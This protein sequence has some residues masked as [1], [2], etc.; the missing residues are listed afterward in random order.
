MG[1]SVRQTMARKQSIE[2]EAGKAEADAVKK[3]K[4]DNK[5]NTQ[6]VDPDL[7]DVESTEAANDKEYDENGDLIVPDYETGDIGDDPD[8]DGE[9]TWPDTSEN[10]L[11]IV[12]SKIVRYDPNIF[13]ITLHRQIPQKPDVSATACRPGRMM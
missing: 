7:S 3:E 11:D 13:F 5:D 2:G 12:K 1:R 9:E 8:A 10:D 6:V 4:E